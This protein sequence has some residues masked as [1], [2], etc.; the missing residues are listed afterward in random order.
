MTLS[1]TLPDFG[2]EK[3][4]NALGVDGIGVEIGELPI[5]PH[6]LFTAII[7]PKTENLSN[8]LIGRSLI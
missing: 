5:T 7:R 6:G 2:F 3:V 8:S 4:N 1:A